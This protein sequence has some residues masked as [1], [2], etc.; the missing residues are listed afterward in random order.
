[1]L[2]LLLEDHLERI[3][4]INISYNFHLQF[5]DTQQGCATRMANTTSYMLQVSSA[6]KGVYVLEILVEG[7]QVAD[8]WIADSFSLRLSN[9]SSQILT[10][11]ALVACF[12]R[13]RS[14]S[15]RQIPSSPFLVSVVERVCNECEPDSPLSWMC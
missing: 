14:C 15:E 6:E 8:V 13:L 12:I 3:E 5:S 2:S 11:I 7:I 1:M 10:T 4:G 9:G